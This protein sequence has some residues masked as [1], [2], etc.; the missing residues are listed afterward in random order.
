MD[1]GL[2]GKSERHDRRRA[3]SGLRSPLSDGDYVVAQ[4]LNVDGGAWMS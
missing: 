2:N 1:L 3:G 4:T